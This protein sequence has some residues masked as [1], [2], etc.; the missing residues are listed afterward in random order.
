MTAAT[1]LPGRPLLP[2]DLATEAGRLGAE[3]RQRRLARR[4]TQAAL[5]ARLGVRQSCLSAWERGRAAPRG[6]TL[7]RL[8]ALLGGGR[9]DV[10]P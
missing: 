9:I 7:L 10:T 4:W 2:T 1:R 3:L 5:A 6:T 8:L